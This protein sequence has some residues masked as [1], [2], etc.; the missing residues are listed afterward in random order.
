M[1]FAAKI[2]ESS[3]Q[4]RAG[5]I[6]DG[7]R[8]PGTIR[9]MSVYGGACGDD[10]FSV[11]ALFS[12]YIEIVLD[13]CDMPLENKELVPQI[14]VLL[15]DGTTEYIDIGYF[16]VTKPKN[17]AYQ[18]TFTAVGRISAKLN[19][20]PDI[21]KTQTIVNLA[22][23][24]TAKTGVPVIFRG[25]TAAGSIEKDLS[26]LTCK[27]ILEVITSVLG[28][29]ATEDNKGNIV[30][31]KY[32]IESPISYNGDRVI[33]LPQFNDY[34]Y[35]LSGVKVI[36]SEK[37]EDEDGNVIPEVAFTEGMP[38]MVIS[39]PYM[40]EALFAN[41]AANTVGYSYRP[42]TVPI[43][44]GD[45]RIEPWDCLSVTDV[46]GNTYTVPCLNI[47][48][49][50]DGGLSTI[51]TA[52]GDS[53]SE[54]ESE[55]RGPITQRLDRMSAELFTAREAIIN[56]L[57]ADDLEAETAKLGYVKADEIDA[58]LG[59]FGYLKT[60]ELEAKI[61]EFGYLK[62]VDADLGYVKINQANI[63]TAWV[64][65]LLV[66]GNFLADTVHAGSGYYSK[67]LVGVNVS[68]D[69]IVGNT[70]KADALILQGE[71]GI[72]RRLNIDSLGQAIVDSDP[73][74]NEKL[75]GS[76]LVA[77]SV[78]AEEIAANAVTSEK[79]LAN[80][81]TAQKIDIEDLQ[82]HLA[83]IGDAKGNHV[84]IDS[85]SVDIK[86]G[87]DVLASFGA[88]TIYLGKNKKDT[89]IEMCGNIGR[90]FVRELLN[91]NIFRSH[92]T[93]EAEDTLSLK[94]PTSN[95]INSS[96][97]DDDMWS[98]AKIGV[99]TAAPSDIGVI[100]SIKPYIH[101]ST[102]YTDK[103]SNVGHLGGLGG[104][105]AEIML[106]SDRLYMAISDSIIG[107]SQSLS[108]NLNESR[109]IFSSGDALEMVHNETGNSIGVGVGSGGI[110]K[111]IYNYD[112]KKWMIYS[113]DTNLYLAP[114]DGG[115]IIA[116]SDIHAGGHII[117]KNNQELIGRNTAGAGYNLVYVNSSDNIVWG[118]Q[119]LGSHFFNM[120]PKKQ[121]RIKS[122]ETAVFNSWYDE[123]KGR[124]ASIPAAHEQT[125]SGGS[126][127]RVGST[128]ILYRY[129]SSSRRY[130]EAITTQLGKELNPEKL[131]D[132]LVVQY[133]YREGHL[134]KTDQR[135]GKEFIG[136]LAED[137]KMKYP[138]AV[139]MGEDGFAENY[140]VDIL[141][142][143]MLKLIQNQK[144]EINNLKEEINEI[145]RNPN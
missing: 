124:Y 134:S 91:G 20:L 104:G 54:E 123:T 66:K 4:F 56:R 127:V 6:L 69:T 120:L 52:P 50:F 40:T 137:I 138:I 93:I 14:G 141:V 51:I 5:L 75:D 80:A 78:T 102:A 111:G 145:K 144:K 133:K 83:R 37:G 68:G 110:N 85:D 116:D 139:N 23:A 118:S 10:G 77:K 55:A 105:N 47:I 42:A 49:T 39:N 2:A 142:P 59:T 73:K 125:T 97:D 3:R 103:N 22:E 38:R 136:L 1:A 41:F 9:S 115:G 17:T 143:A 119:S 18:T 84:L 121:F 131:Y 33:E 61:G 130:K 98:D 74:Y 128:G 72:Y 79:I 13:G 21:P 36:V 15:D 60:D 30:I 26:G 107:K 35:T 117:L 57:K 31:S 108:L 101:L 34:D 94:S 90:I 53:E 135:Y 27:E 71:D 113:N 28:G 122:G 89:T 63:D 126:T 29:F 132:L 8:V 82:T 95:W 129:V 109:A 32:S 112:A 19:V 86:L 12:S 65:D 25:L 92:F 140:N 11:G 88:N 87:D 44:L 64:E 48:H 96:Y 62:A 67:D 76:I 45:P 114:P 58:K 7:E 81:V 100:K 16:T 70:V 46:K 43:A 106:T 24:I 99:V